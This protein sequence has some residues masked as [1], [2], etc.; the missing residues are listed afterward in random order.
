VRGGGARVFLGL[1]SF[2]DAPDFAGGANREATRRGVGV[3]SP[4]GDRLRCMESGSGTM[5]DHVSATLT[6]RVNVLPAS[7]AWSYFLDGKFGLSA[8]ESLRYWKN[9]NI[10]PVFYIIYCIILFFICYVN[11]VYIFLNLNIQIIYFKICT[12]FT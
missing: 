8:A 1:V 6:L 3:G 10:E 5:W 11:I 4:G 12:M 9:N 7:R 2:L